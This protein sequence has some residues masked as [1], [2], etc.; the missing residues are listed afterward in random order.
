MPNEMIPNVRSQ[1]HRVPV[2]DV[3]EAGQELPT[4]SAGERL[5]NKILYTTTT[6]QNVCFTCNISISY[7]NAL[8]ML[9]IGGGGV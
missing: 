2:A 9:Y 8:L 3:D 6:I 7:I 1:G 4:G 5:G